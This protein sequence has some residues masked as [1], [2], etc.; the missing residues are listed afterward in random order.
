MNTLSIYNQDYKKI[1]FTPAEGTMKIKTPDHE[2]GFGLLIVND[3]G[4]DTILTLKGGN[5]IFSAG[6]VIV[7][8]TQDTIIVNLKNTGRYKNVSKGIDFLVFII[9]LINL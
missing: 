7:P 9:K 2:E 4:S 5:S 6:D 3:S 8:L 1:T